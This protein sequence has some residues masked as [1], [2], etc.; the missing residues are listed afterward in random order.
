MKHYIKTPWRAFTA[1]LTATVAVAANSGPVFSQS[2]TELP[3]VTV[4]GAPLNESLTVFTTEQAREEIQRT[5]GAVEVISDEDFKKGPAATLKDVLDY[6]PGVFVQPKWGAD[7]R[8]SIRGSSLSRNFHLRS[9]QLY[10]DGIPINTADG[11]GD[12]QEIDP[13]AYRHVDVYKGGNALRFGGNSLGGAI[14]FVTPSGRDAS[15]AAGSADVGGYG[16]NRQQASS[17]AAF[18]PVDYFI[19]AARQ[20]QDGFRDHTG[21]DSYRGSVN[22]GYQLTPD[23]ETRFYINANNVHQRI[24]GEVKKSSALSSPEGGVNNN[25]KNDYQRNIDTVRVANKTTLRFESTTVDLGVFGVNRRLVHPIFQLIDYSYH[26]YGGFV[27]A[28]DERSILGRKNRAVAGFNI[29]NGRV[30]NRQY[31]N[32]LGLRGAPQSSSFDSSEN[33]IAYGEDSFSVIPD[34][35]VVGGLQ[36]THAVR[37]RRDTF[38]SNGDASGRNSFT[39]LSPKVGLLWDVDPDWQIFTNVS[40]SAEAPS[41][42]EGSGTVIPF[43]A[44]KEQ[45]ATTYEIGTRGQR[46]D[47]KWNLAAYRAKIHNELQCLQSTV[48]SCNVTNVHRTIHQGLEVGAG[49]NVLHD[50]FSRTDRVWL[51]LAYTFSDFKFENDRSFNDNQLP[52]APRHFLR[53]ELLYKHPIGLSIGPNME[54]VPK[55]YFADNANTLKTDPYVIFGIKAVQDFNENVSAYIEG[56][57]LG[58]TA[59]IANASVINRATDNS[60]QFNPG[61]GRSAFAGIRAKW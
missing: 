6:V 12:F 51:N 39:L 9:I 36:V 17:G 34:V 41:F 30:D 57:N 46:P 23:I 1:A 11:Y 35:A 18:G 33:Y 40:R 7:A 20:Q 58:D 50:L 38:L 10:M 52:G 54:W 55:G 31:T 4:I 29:I 61:D 48:S 21:G 25:I 3:A 8:L 47:Y 5:P 59:Y 44:I 43:T 14:N 32:T 16:F 28:V 24:P 53:S 2:A 42:S 13:S 60:A 15:I 27:R 56:R 49:A 19:T 37:D 26:D 45:T 22:L